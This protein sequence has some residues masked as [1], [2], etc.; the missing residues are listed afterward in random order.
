MITV[1]NRNESE[2]NK[3]E[4]RRSY[5]DNRF[6]Y[7]KRL[8]Y[9]PDHIHIIWECEWLSL[10]ESDDDVASYIKRKFSGKQFMSEMEIIEK[11][12]DSTMFAAVQCDIAVPDV[13]SDEFKN[14]PNFGC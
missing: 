5:T 2:K 3:L 14:H 7:F 12:R 10:V 9:N 4:K 1:A 13:W 11:I 8:G 6:E